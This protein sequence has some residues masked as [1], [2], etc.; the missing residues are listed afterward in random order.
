[1]ADA[2][3][4]AR[5]LA[6]P[7]RDGRVSRRHLARVQIRRWIPIAILQALQRAIHANVISIAVASEDV[8]GKDRKPP[9]ALRWVNSLPSLRRLAGYLVAMG[10][11]PEHAPKYAQR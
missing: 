7:L 2:V 9:A 1:V 3:A 5:I 6:R 11:L 10:P 8:D 4:A